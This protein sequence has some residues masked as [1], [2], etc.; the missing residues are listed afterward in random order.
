MRKFCHDGPFQNSTSQVLP[1]RDATQSI[2]PDPV[3]D[4]YVARGNL[5]DLTESKLKVCTEISFHVNGG[6]HSFTNFQ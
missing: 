3:C 2:I 1:G 6:L 4:S 5:R